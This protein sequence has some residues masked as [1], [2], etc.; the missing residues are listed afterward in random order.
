MQLRWSCGSHGL[1]ARLR[2]FS[3]EIAAQMEL[4]V[5]LAWYEINLYGRVNLVRGLCQFDVGFFS[6]LD[7]DYRAYSFTKVEIVEVGFDGA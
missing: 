4:Q 3:Q 6:T 7:Q 2:G 5:S 1:G